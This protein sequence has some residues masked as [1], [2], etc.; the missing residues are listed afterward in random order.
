VKLAVLAT[1]TVI[2]AMGWTEQDSISAIYQAS[3]RYSVPAPLLAAI[4]QCESQFD[5]SAIG[6]DGHD[7]GLFQL[8]YPGGVGEGCGLT[9]DQLLNPYVNADCAASYIRNM[10]DAFHSWYKATLAW[11]TIFTSNAVC[12]QT[13]WGLYQD[14]NWQARWSRWYEPPPEQMIKNMAIMGMVLLAVWKVGALI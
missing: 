1:A 14:E 2:I 7:Y 11:N 6:P 4:A 12:P 10:Y 5:A 13:A 9:P 3:A 8:R